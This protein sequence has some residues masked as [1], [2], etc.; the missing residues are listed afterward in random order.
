MLQ[1]CGLSGHLSVSLTLLC[2]AAEE[3]AGAA[4]EQV[5]G[6]GAQAGAPH[7]PGRVLRGHPHPEPGNTIIKFTVIQD[8]NTVHCVTRPPNIF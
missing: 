2:V 4:A 5:R 3:E 7:P 6:R 8:N 1:Q